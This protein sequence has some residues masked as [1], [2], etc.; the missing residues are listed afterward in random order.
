MPVKRHPNSWKT[1]F[2]CDVQDSETL[3]E[4]GHKLPS[5][6]D[7]NHPFMGHLKGTSIGHPSDIYIHL[8]DICQPH[9]ECNGCG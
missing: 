1:R 4:T 6:A 8:S 2:S 5:N 9:P 3:T 7:E